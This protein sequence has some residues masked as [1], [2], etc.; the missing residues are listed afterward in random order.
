MPSTVAALSFVCM[1][2]QSFGEAQGQKILLQHAVPLCLSIS[3]SFHL[4]PIKLLKAKTRGEACSLQAPT[5]AQDLL[6]YFKSHTAANYKD[7]KLI[8]MHDVVQF[9]HVHVC[10]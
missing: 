5:A 1:S 3:L 4:K 6:P 9:D 8:G 7:I 2:S 10:M